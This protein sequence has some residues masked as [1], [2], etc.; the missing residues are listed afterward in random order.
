MTKRTILIITLLLLLFSSL[1]VVYFLF[2]KPKPGE[3]S[4][5]TASEETQKLW[6]LIQSQASQLK[7]ESYPQP[8]RTYLDELQSKQRYEW[9]GN[10]EKA[11]SYIRSFYPDER[12]DVLFLLHINYSHYLEDWEA[13][14]RDQSRTDWEKWQK[15]EDLREHYFP[16]VKS[17]LFEDHPTVVLQSFL[18][19]AEDF[20]LKN[21]QT[22]SQERRKAFQKK[23]KE[24]YKENPI[25]IQS[26]ESAEFHRKLVKLIYAR[27]L[28]LMTE[29][30][31]QEFIEKQWEK[32]EQGLF[33]N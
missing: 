3:A 22:Y 2:R 19:F 27:E 25:E 10:R 30:Q 18:Y 29:A 33:W 1:F 6:G 23:R 11:L 13:L 20:V 12:G 9:Y 16:V 28:S 5:P 17:L 4:H 32:E 26:W 8:L 24:M 14:E 31:K 21:P 7:S 15:R